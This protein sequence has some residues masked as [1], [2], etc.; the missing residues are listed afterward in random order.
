MRECFH[1]S[2]ER[3]W[4][5]LVRW[6][7]GQKVFLISFI[8]SYSAGLR[9]VFESSSKGKHIVL[10]TVSVCTGDRKCCCWICWV[11]LTF[12]IIF[13]LHLNTFL[14]LQQLIIPW[15]IKSVIIMSPTTFHVTH[16]TQLPNS[17]QFF[18][19][20]LKHFMVL[21]QPTCMNQYGPSGRL[22]RVL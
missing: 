10:C 13:N 1:C 8:E 4:H 12:L 2:R 20:V 15:S 19:L 21:H 5:C 17:T 16:V 11:L 18:L 9:F 7:W 22:A 6:N 14:K 3:E